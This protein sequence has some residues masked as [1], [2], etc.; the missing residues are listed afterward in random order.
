MSSSEWFAGENRLPKK[1]SLMP[2][3]MSLR[4]FTVTVSN[5]CIS[6]YIE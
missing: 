1:V 5:E 4:K 6:S 3:G 2:D